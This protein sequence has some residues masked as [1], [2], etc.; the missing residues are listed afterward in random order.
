M[1]TRSLAAWTV[2]LCLLVLV[3]AAVGADAGRSADAGPHLFSVPAEGRPAA[4]LARTD[5]DV[6]ARYGGFEL[7]RASGADADRLRRAGADVR[8]DMRT[9]RLGRN[10]V[11]PLTDRAPLTTK[12][13]SGGAHGLAV[14]QFVGPIKD[15]WLERLRSTGVRVVSY[16][17]ANAYLVSGTFEEL[18]RL[19]A[20]TASDPAFRA[21]VE[22][23]PADKLGAGIRE[24]G[25]QRFAI[26]T[27]SG[28]D[29]EDAR[30]EVDRA[31]E[32]MRP[33]SSLG[34]YRTQY[35]ILDVSEAGAIAA[36]PGVV[37]V[38]PAPE[39][40]LF[41]ERQ[42]QIVAD[43]LSGPDPLVPT[44]PGYLAFYDGLGL[45][46]TR[47]PFV[48]DVTDSGFDKGSTAAD[49]Q[50]DFHQGGV[51]GNPSRVAYALDYTTDPD[52]KDCGGHGTINAS[53]IGGFNNGTGATVEDAGSFNYGLGVAPYAQ[54]GAS[55]IFN[56]AEAFSLSGTIA[57][58]QSAAYAEGA[59]IANHSWGAATGGAYTA[60]SQTFDALVR[61]AQGGVGGN[62]QMVEVVAGGNAGPGANTVLNLATAKNVIAVGAT[63]TVHG[64]GITPNPD[65][66]SVA[67]TGADDA[68][69]MATFSS[70]GPTDDLRTKPDIVGPGTHITGAQS[71]ATGY[72]G[73][74]VCDGTFPTGGTLYNRSSG[75]S[76]STPLVS[77]MA[78]I[79]R[80]WFRQNRGGGIVVPS[81][82][83][84]KAA[85]AN[86]ARDIGGGEGVGG[87]VPSQSQGWGLGSL[88]RL[89]DGGPRFFS[90]QQTTF[91]NTGDTS[92]RVFAVQDPSKPVRVTLAW[93]DAP[94]PTFGNSFVND[95]DLTV[96]SG[97][98]VFKGNVFS[99]G[100][101]I[102]G[103]AADPRNNLEGVYL[104]AGSSGNF[105]VTVTAA[106]IAGDG[107]P[108]SG[109][110]TDQDFAL[111]VSNAAEVTGPAL[112]GGGMTVSAVGGDSD[113]V[114]EPGERFSVT[115]SVQNVGTATATG[116][117]GTLAGSSPVTITDGAAAWPALAPDADALNA[118]PITGRVAPGAT[119][120]APTTVTLDI[121]SSEGSSMSRS[122]TI[123]PGTGVSSPNSADVPKSIPDNSATGVSSTLT[124]SGPGTIQDLNVRIA[125][126]T[127]TWVGDLQI[128]LRSPLG[129]VVWLADRPG[130][131]S[132]SGDNFT[133]T[134]FDDQASTTLGAAGTAAPYTGSFKPQS[135]AQPSGT[136]SAFIGQS[137]TG[138]WTLDVFDLAS[139][140]TGTLQS[141]GLDTPVS[142]CD[143]VPPAAPGQPTGL[144]LTQGTGSVDLDWADTPTATSY[145][146]YRRTSAGSYPAS[147]VGTSNES[148]FSDTP[149][150][151]GSYCYKVGAL[152]DASPGPLSEEQCSAGGTPPGGTPGGT[153][154]GQQPG[155]QQ[156]GGTGPGG[157]SP[158]VISLASLAKLV[159][160]NSKG[161]FTLKFGGTAGQAGSIKLT[162]VKAFA[163]AK[164]KLVVARK[165]FTIPATG[166]VKLKLKLTRAG[167][168]VLKRQKRLPVS[169]QVTLGSQKA[170]K[171][172]TLKAPR[173]R[174]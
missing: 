38:Q 112:T 94:G 58:E 86:S 80:E 42:D 13:R 47:F 11:D 73:V 44:G 147:P 46:T 54:V 71:H 152:N 97:A 3:S 106:N 24:T 146:I 143:F 125:S 9:V 171:R 16:M 34:P 83:L 5:A 121:T 15:A 89:I 29:G 31:G 116:I 59:R 158:V 96:G 50:P 114:V 140:D 124:L 104:P 139:S 134:V 102:P 48:V 136:L 117:K 157:E 98:G 4:S 28:A 75:T 120:G 151:G 19:S 57:A 101:S 95:L 132:N 149:P 111:V 70:R 1:R 88:A 10:Q 49:S 35:A 173:P 110:A 107:V 168:K 68:H 131:A 127:H 40:E 30:G 79:F 64:S 43:A 36:D 105:R 156:P 113:S 122:A 100:V 67:N 41:D 145:E 159:N 91:T 84:T 90:D 51:L 109:D 74:G 153:P 118:D 82:A 123:S 128:R 63:E 174:R 77:G 160:V 141:W 53:I 78:A 148:S 55:K 33:T 155:G 2:V 23:R 14:A 17:A 150:G 61:D 87:A 137:M 65:G 115:Q 76:H 163:S 135:G 165:S 32:K 103:G 6:I 93:T 166:T 169:A 99:G 167:L 172:L 161:V 142:V 154:G 66:C 45:G 37:S 52:A 25:R 56:C 62:Q 22:L 12:G 126:I 129:T 39:P 8:D 20:M 164:R 18:E 60:D 69:D 144:T 85:L 130:G 27:L 21:L 162:T 92:K 7:V 26:Q 72:T 108:G 81:P 138:T 133:N 119:C 170:A